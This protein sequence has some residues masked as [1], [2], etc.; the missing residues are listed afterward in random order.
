MHTNLLLAEGIVVAGIVAGTIDG[1][2]VTDCAFSAKSV[3]KASNEAFL[4]VLAS[5]VRLFGDG[6]QPPI[7]GKVTAERYVATSGN[8]DLRC[9]VFVW[10]PDHAAIS[11]DGAVGYTDGPWLFTG[12]A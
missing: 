9:N 7:F 11:S 12:P 3:F 8:G 6:S 1:L 4:A 2:V 5:D 10:T